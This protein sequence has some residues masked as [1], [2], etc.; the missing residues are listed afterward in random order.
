M[1]LPSFKQL[2]NCSLMP[3]SSNIIEDRLFLYLTTNY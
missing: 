1:S 2:L 3:L